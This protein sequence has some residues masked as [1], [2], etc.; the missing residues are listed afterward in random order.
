VALALYDA[1]GKD[2]PIVQESHIRQVV[3]MSRA[4]KDYIR[5]THDDMDESEMAYRSGLRDDKKISRE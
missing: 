4:F 1:K 2:T 5:S 3:S